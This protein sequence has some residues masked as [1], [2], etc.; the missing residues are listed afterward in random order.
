[1]MKNRLLNVSLI[2]LIL[3]VIIGC[4]SVEVRY[5]GAEKMGYYEVV[6]NYNGDTDYH[7]GQLYGE[8]LVSQYPSMEAGFANYFSALSTEEYTT[9]MARI[10]SI[11]SQIP[12]EH[13]DFI[14]GLASKFSGGINNDK[15]DGM[16]SED[17]VSY[18]SLTG[19]VHRSSQCSV[20]AAYESMSATN[21]PIIGRLLD[22]SNV[23]HGAIYYIKKGNKKIMNIGATL[24][25]Q[26]ISTGL[27]QYGIFVAT[28]DAPTGEPFPDLSSDTYYSYHF[29]L[30]YALETYNT[31]EDIANYLTQK[32]YTY[33]HLVVIGDAS[34]MKVLENNLSGTRAL[35]DSASELN[36]GVT[37]EFPN[38]I[39]AVNAFVLSGNFD[40]FSIS[41]YNTYR[42]QSIKD[43]LALYTSDNIITVDEMKKIATYYGTDINQIT[44]GGIMT[45]ITQQIVIYDSASSSL[46][47]F[48]RNNRSSGTENTTDT[49]DVDNPNFLEIPVRF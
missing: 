5:V 29:D 33:N 26:S 25:S 18:F 38:A 37:W 34:T 19:D 48:F 8:V 6:L 45:F 40:N 1:M 35:R 11:N 2:V 27:N 41:P 46:Q 17:E 47:M 16:L 21:K 24:L 43:Q 12:R 36:T 9:I 15:A 31:I 28:L 20:V 13:R 42:W 49:F 44:D 3:F 22:W 23:P 4:G 7:M 32:K 14:K 39:A 10:Q 30:R